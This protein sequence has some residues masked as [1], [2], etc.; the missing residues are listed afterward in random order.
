MRKLWI[1]ALSAFVL[2]ALTGCGKSEKYE[3]EIIIP[4][5]S[6]AEYV[7]ADEEISPT[8]KKI[9]M[10]C[11]TQLSIPSRIYTEAWQMCRTL[12]GML[13]KLESIHVKRLWTF[14]S[15]CFSG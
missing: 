7:Y 4:A 15:V 13:F 3:I 2:F 8:G 10:H 12:H 9:E 14:F 1:A 6:Q 11:Q 5:G